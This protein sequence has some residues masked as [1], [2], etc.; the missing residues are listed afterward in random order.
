MDIPGYILV[1]QGCM[2]LLFWGLRIH[3]IPDH[4]LGCFSTEAAPMEHKDIH[5]WG[6][7]LQVGRVS[8][9]QLLWTSRVHVTIHSD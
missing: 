7:G 9:E 2:G 5:T 4:G 3:A 1:M 6:T 8:T